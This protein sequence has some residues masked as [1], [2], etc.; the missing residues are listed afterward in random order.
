MTMHQ[1]TETIRSRLCVVLFWLASNYLQPDW[2][3]CITAI[4]KNDDENFTFTN[5]WTLNF[6]IEWC[7][8][9]LHLLGLVILDKTKE[10]FYD[11]VILGSVCIAFFSAYSFRGINDEQTP[12]KRNSIFFVSV[13]KAIILCCKFF[14]RLSS[15]YTLNVERYFLFIFLLFTS[16][17]TMNLLLFIIES[18]FEIVRMILMH[19]VRSN[20]HWIISLHYCTHEEINAH[21]KKWVDSF[22]FIS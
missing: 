17:K 13:S 11:A 10:H 5:L 22:V 16:S 20:C 21:E 9:L 14:D 1:L 12:Q 4:E 3:E 19:Y 18:A 7:F 6:N 8:I 15:T 2:N